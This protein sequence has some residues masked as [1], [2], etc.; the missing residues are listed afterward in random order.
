MARNET[1]VAAK[2][3]Q[4]PLFISTPTGDSPA[5]AAKAK[6]PK[7]KA[8]AK[9]EAPAPAEKNGK[10]KGSLSP[11]QE[12]ALKALAK[13]DGQTGSELAASAEIDS[14]SIGLVVGY[15]D[16]SV[17]AQEVHSSNLVGRGLV[18]VTKERPFTYHL[19]AKGRKALGK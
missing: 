9:A 19:T 6:A 2:K 4:A 7:A 18:R 17:Q 14:A 3:E 16:V 1:N 12:R 11:R 8:K 5:P 15:R 10:D 13:R